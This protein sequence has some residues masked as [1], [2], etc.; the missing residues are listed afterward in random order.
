[1]TTPKLG[2]LEL[3]P[4]RKVWAHEERNFTPWLAENLHLLSEVVDMDLELIEV[5]SILRAAGRV[6][7][8]VLAGHEVAR[9]RNR[10]AES[11]QEL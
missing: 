5:E 1:M 3:V 2:K 4:L 8:H 9:Q 10:P 11:A 6:H 7:H